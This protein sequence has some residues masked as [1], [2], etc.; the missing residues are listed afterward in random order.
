[1]Q[2]LLSHVAV[3]ILAVVGII[4]IVAAAIQYRTTASHLIGAGSG[5]ALALN[6]QAPMCTLDNADTGSVLFIGCGGFF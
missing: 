2:Q 5:S 4:G 3:R 6:D 1:M